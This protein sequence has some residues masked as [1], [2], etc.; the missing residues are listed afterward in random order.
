[1]KQNIIFLGCTSGYGYAFSA[2]NSKTEFMARGAVEQ[3]DRVTIHNGI[4]GLKELSARTVLHK[5]GLCDVISYPK[6]GNQLVS[7]FY[8]LSNLRTDL[9]SLYM[10]DA[11]NI[12]ILEAPDYHIYRIYC[13]YAHKFGYKVAVISHEWL[14]TIGDIHP[15]RRPFSNLYTK[16]FGNYADAILPIS[17]Y[18]IKKIEHFHK[19]YFKVP[20]LASFGDV[21]K[22]PVETPYFLYCVYAAYTRVILPLIEAFATFKKLDKNGYKL[23]LVLG[24]ADYQV[25]VVCDF[26]SEHGYNN[27]IEIRRK[28]PYT[29]LM[30]LYNN[31]SGLLIPLDPDSEQD[32]ARFSQKIAEYC[33]SANPIISCKLGEVDYYFKDK[34]TAIFCDYSKDGFVEA[35]KWVSENPK[36]SQ[37]VGFAGYELGKQKFNYIVVGKQLHDFFETI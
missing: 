11:I 8:N 30:D 7:W 9:R 5:D 26:I 2:T 17:E 13:Y 23:I 20:V 36:E 37:E 35:F 32:H 25:K 3:G 10:D 21:V 18:I 12:V 16:T 24:G 33:S 15:L 29:E 28:I 22:R 27:I 14:P 6:K 19:P 31:A 4:L 1:M 34:E